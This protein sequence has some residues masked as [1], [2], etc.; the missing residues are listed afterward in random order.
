MDNKEI[1]SRLLDIL[2]SVDNICEKEKISYMLTQG[3]LLGAIREK[4]FI[5]WDVEDADIM[6]HRKD[7]NVFMAYCKKHSDDLIFFLGRDDHVYG[8]VPRLKFK[9]NPEIFVEIFL[10]DLLPKNIFIRRFKFIKLIFIRGMLSLSTNISNDKTTI[11]LKI[12]AFIMWCL[13]CLGKLFDRETKQNFYTKASQYYNEG[14]CG[15]IFFS[16]EAMQK[17]TVQLDKTLLNE[18]L[19]VPFEDTKLM[20][21]KEW[22]RILKFYYGDGYMVPKREN[23]KE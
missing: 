19:S 23:Y 13:R 7:F 9:H 6:M 16:N 21:P 14:N 1:H 3:T 2:K 8:I 18:T 15:T 4:G 12:K 17:M 22:D 11:A 10:I 20:I 5:E